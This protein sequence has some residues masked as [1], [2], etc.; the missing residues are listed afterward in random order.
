[1]FNDSVMRIYTGSQPA[2]ADTGA[3]GTLLV[4]ITKASGALSVST[5]QMSSVTLT[6]NG[7]DTYTLVVTI[8]GTDYTYSVVRVAEDATALA[9]ALCILINADKY[10]F[11]AHAA[12]V[13]TVASRFPGEAYSIANTGSSTPGNVVIAVVTAD[14]RGNGLHWIDPAS[15]VV[16][17]ETAY[18][19]SGVAVSTGTAGYF[20]LSEYGDTPTSL[21]TTAMRVDGSIGTSGTDCTVGSTSITSGATVTIDSAAFTLPANA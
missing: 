1:M 17:K 16:S 11:A 7:T 9:E 3:T 19:W 20:R 8:S 13:I 18:A 12:G 14:A 15:G 4:T 5:R 10:V 2:S 6:A 21:S